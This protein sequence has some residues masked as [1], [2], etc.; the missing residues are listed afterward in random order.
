MNMLYDIVS[1]VFCK[2]KKT[3]KKRYCSFTVS[4]NDKTINSVLMGVTGFWIGGPANLISSAIAA[5]LG[6]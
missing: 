6:K 3:K 5:D 4:P 2:K 1:L